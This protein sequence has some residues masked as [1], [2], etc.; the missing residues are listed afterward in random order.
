MEVGHGFAGVRAVVDDQAK[1]SIEAE[2]ARDLAGGE[3]EVTEDR[4]LIGSGLADPRNDG[5]GNQQEV[6]GGLRL[7]VMDHDAV[8]VLVFDSGRNFAGDDAFEEGGHGF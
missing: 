3:Q 8:V 7:N 4:G 5:L 6:D 2:F 1:T